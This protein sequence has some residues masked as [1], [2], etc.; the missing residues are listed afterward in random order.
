MSSPLH[1]LTSHTSSAPPC[2]YMHDKCHDVCDMRSAA[3]Q[4]A[5]VAGGA[6]RGGAG[7][8]KVVDH[9]PWSAEQ[10]DP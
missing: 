5:T 7:R 3:A 9:D 2:R 4:F 8:V 1:Q 6:S 10:R